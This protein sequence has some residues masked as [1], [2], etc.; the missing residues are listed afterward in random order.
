MYHSRR[1]EWLFLEC[2]RWRWLGKIP[3][4]ESLSSVF[5]CETRSPSFHCV[6]FCL[7]IHEGRV[8][9]CFNN[10]IYW[11]SSR[12]RETERALC[13]L[14]TSAELSPIFFFRKKWKQ[15]RSNMSISQRGHYWC[16]RRKTEPF[17]R[18][19]PSAIAPKM[20]KINKLI[21]AGRATCFPVWDSFSPVWPLWL[22]SLLSR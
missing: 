7:I 3:S 5:V 1:V 15:K 2:S 19:R 8:Q 20:W 12:L 22:A 4:R 16:Q 17:T 13:L 9:L 21:A 14:P 18:R 6:Y 10:F 11:L